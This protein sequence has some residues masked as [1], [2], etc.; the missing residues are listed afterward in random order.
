MKA[1]M[2]LVIVTMV[3]SFS[4]AAEEKVDVGA[5]KAAIKQ[6]ALDYI[7]GWF[8]GNPERMDRALH[9]DLTKRGLVKERTT[10]GHFLTYLTKSNMVEYTKAGYGKRIPKDKWGIDVQVLDIYKEIALAKAL[11]VQFMDYLQLAKY[12]GQWKIINVLW[13]PVPAPPPPPKPQKDQ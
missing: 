7:E 11:S 8:E 9:P 5:E 6:A 10:G 4:W 1:A 3:F 12:N 2:L 13:T